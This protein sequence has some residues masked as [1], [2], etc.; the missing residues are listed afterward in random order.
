MKETEAKFFFKFASFVNFVFSEASFTGGK[1][2]ISLVH[3]L[4]CLYLYD[5]YYKQKQF[6][7]IGLARNDGKV[8]VKSKVN[9]TI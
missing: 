9:K 4:I 3:F 5:I 8:Q 1:F 2:E 6:L 7:F